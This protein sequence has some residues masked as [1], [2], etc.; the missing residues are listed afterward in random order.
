[1]EGNLLY[2]RSTDLNVNLMQKTLS[3][4]HLGQC[5]TT[6]LGTVAQLCWCIESILTGNKDGFVYGKDGEDELELIWKCGARLP[7][8][9]DYCLKCQC[10]RG[11]TGAISGPQPWP[12]QSPREP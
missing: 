5:L 4:K 11:H 9:H 2:L 1:M 7:D 6:Y 12:L 3:W 8:F 10:Y